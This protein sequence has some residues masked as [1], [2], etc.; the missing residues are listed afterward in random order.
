MESGPFSPFRLSDLIAFIAVIVALLSPFVAWWLTRRSQLNDQKRQT[1]QSIFSALMENR[2]M[3]ESKETVRA[4]NLIDVAFHDH[5][6]VRYL[7]REYHSMITK[8]AFFENLIGLELRNQKLL[9]LQTEMARVLGYNID[10]FD[11]ERIYA[12]NWLDEEQAIARH[13]RA[14]RAAAMRA[15]RETGA[16][17]NLPKAQSSGP[18]PALYLMQYSAPQ[19]SSGFG[20]IYLG[21]G[22]LGGGDAAG[23]RYEGTYHVIGD[24]LVISATMYV[25][26]GGELATGFKAE[27]STSLPL[28]IELPLSFASGQEHTLTIGDQPLNIRFE[29]IK[30]L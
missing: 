26:A 10:Q 14:T 16:P 5:Q 8:P 17:Q 21:N 29:K 2:H 23:V 25:P 3:V 24:R 15:S 6:R 30:D 1:R 27:E 12:P 18:N 7:W 9:E 11:V 20:S 28:N 4:L 13:D 19:G 22:V